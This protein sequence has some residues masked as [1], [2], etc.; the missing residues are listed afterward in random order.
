MAERLFIS[1]QKLETWIEEG[2]VTFENNVLTLL[3]EKVS[4]TLEPAVRILSL[5]DG[6]DKAGLMGKAVTVAELLA[7]KAE[8]F[9]DSVILGDCAYQC[10]EGF[11][12]TIEK[13]SVE[14]GT[15]PAARDAPAKAADK[16]ADTASGADML[17]DFMLKHM[18]R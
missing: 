5:I 8:Y 2:K 6:E 7:K 10:E 17:A 9:R 16:P 14:T 4:Y 1:Q 12:G 13:P 11:M 18:G 3:A 15:P